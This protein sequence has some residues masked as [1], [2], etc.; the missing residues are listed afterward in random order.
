MAGRP[1][2]RN[3]A[4]RGAMRVIA[5]CELRYFISADCSLGSLFNGEVAERIG[6]YTNNVIQ[7]AAS[8]KKE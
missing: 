5:G 7:G 2:F 6:L 4:I 1:A 3:S 8:S